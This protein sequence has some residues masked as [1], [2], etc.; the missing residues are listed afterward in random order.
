MVN[1]HKVTWKI[2]ATNH[3]YKAKANFSKYTMKTTN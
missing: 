3:S 1:K 2:L